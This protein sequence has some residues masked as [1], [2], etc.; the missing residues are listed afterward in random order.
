MDFTYKKVSGDTSVRTVAV[1][2]E[3][4]THVEGIDISQLDNDELIDF[5]SAYNNLL[6]NYNQQQLNLLKKFDLKNNYRKFKP[7][8]MSDVE[9]NYV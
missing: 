4:N 7:E 9:T 3:P 8:Q 2:S 6:D 1:L 5:V